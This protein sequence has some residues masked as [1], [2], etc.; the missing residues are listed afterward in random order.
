M[1]ALRSHS[2]GAPGSHGPLER[3]VLL[4]GDFFVRFGGWAGRGDTGNSGR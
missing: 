2:P 4:T 3:G 1:S